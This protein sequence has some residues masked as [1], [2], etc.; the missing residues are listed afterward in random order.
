MSGE[1]V[2]NAQR[3]SDSTLSDSTHIGF[4]IQSVSCF[5]FDSKQS[6]EAALSQV[7]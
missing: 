5:R 6:R 3:I 1:I 4:D 7:S 2:D